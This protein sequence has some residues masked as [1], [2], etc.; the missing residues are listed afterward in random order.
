[1]E[2]TFAWYHAGYQWFRLRLW[3]HALPER[4][5][6]RLAYL[7]PRRMA[8]FAF[9]RVYACIGDCGPDFARVCDEWERRGHD[10]D[11]TRVDR[12]PDPLMTVPQRPTEVVRDTQTGIGL[13]FVRGSDATVDR[14]LSRFWVQ[15]PHLW[16]DAVREATGQPVVSTRA[17]SSSSSSVKATD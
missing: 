10:D 6:W 14:D 16:V 8:Y 13:R 7:L 12:Q 17:T 15:A 3:W 11:F 9:I 1:M 2:R 4:W 5:A